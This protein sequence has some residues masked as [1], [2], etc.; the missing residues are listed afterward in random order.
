MGEEAVSF[1]KKLLGTANLNRLAPFDPTK[2][3]KKK[4]V[5]L[6]DPVD[7]SADKLA[8][9]AESLSVSDG[10]ESTFTGLKKKKKKPVETNILNEEIGD[11][12]DD[13]NDHP[14]EDDEGEVVAQQQHYPW[15]GSDRDYIYEEV[16]ILNS[17]YV[18]SLLSEVLIY[19]CGGVI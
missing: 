2:K 14:G 6:Q 10:L 4:K 17:S 19:L 7:D 13:L 9:T 1:Y 18:F 8:E 3:K 16:Y 12:A 15:E 5:V 11:V